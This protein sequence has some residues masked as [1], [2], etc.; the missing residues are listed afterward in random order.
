MKVLFDEFAFNQTHGGVSRY[1]CEMIKRLPSDIE[2]ELSLKTTNNVYLQDA[3]FSIPPMEKSFG[4][5]ARSHFGPFMSRAL[6][7]LYQGISSKFPGAF[8]FDED[9]NRMHFAKC[10]DKLDFD[11]LHVTD[12]HP[13]WDTWRNVK[14]RRPIVATIHDLI[15]ELYSPSCIAIK[16]MRARLA[17]DADHLIAV[18]NATKQDLIRMYGVPEEKITVVYHGFLPQKESGRKLDYIPDKYILYVGQRTIGKNYPLFSKSIVVLLREIPDLHLFLTG[19][20]LTKNESEWFRLNGVLDRVHQKFVCDED[21]PTV[22]AKA[23]VFVCPSRYEGFGIPILD[24]MSA[25]TPIV[26]ARAS[27]L[28]EVGGDAALY[29]DQDDGMGMNNQV[30]KLLSSP[31]LRRAQSIKGLNRSKLFSWE[32]CAEET[33]E[34][35]REVCENWK[36]RHMR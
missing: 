26:L 27:C 33:A 14:S 11:L 23:T 30:R 1:F 17:S 4:S 25:G 16:R 13:R 12:P 15:P 8:K 6:T 34:I 5:F 9:C 35:Y 3:P 24:A 22:F 10:V 2:W 20:P 19:N 36:R 21:M 7:R 31:E 29:F 32:K 18:S 28:P